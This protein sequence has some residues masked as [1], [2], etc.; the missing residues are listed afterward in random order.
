MKAKLKAFTV[1]EI[2]VALAIMSILLTIITFSLNRFNEQ[3]KL[4]AD[5]HDE[6]NQFYLVR[7]TL[8]NDLYHSDSMRY[9]QNK[10][11]LFT[12]GKQLDYF[13]EDNI[14]MRK[15][16]AGVSNLK[17]PIEEIRFEDKDGQKKVLFSFLWK[18]ENMVLTYQQQ[19]DL[20]EK[21]N[22]TF[23]QLQ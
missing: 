4:S 2:T 12:N 5:V 6:L 11:S 18:G 23:R 22:Q 19:A 7:S 21:I 3:V 16:L 1:F 15:N 14:L 13:V 8:W 20:S 10:L 9:E 17:V